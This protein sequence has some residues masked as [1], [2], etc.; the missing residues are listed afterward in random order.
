[1]YP[2][3]CA[4]AVGAA[5]T[6]TPSRAGEV[7]RGNTEARGSQSNAKTKTTKKQRGGAVSPGKTLAGDG[8]S[9][10]GKTLAGAARPNAN[11]ASHP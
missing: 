8:L 2:F 5:P 11:R 10:P 6:A 1:M 3:T 7:N 9:S 4:R